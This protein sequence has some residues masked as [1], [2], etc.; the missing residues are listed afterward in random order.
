MTLARRHGRAVRILAR[1]K[2]VL[3]DG[4]ASSSS[5]TARPGSTPRARSGRSSPSRR[6]SCARTASSRTCAL[7][8]A[9]GQPIQILTVARQGRPGRALRAAPLERA[10]AR[11]GRAAALPG[12]EGRDRP[13]DRR[14]ASTTTSSSPSRSP[15]PTSSGSRTRSGASSPRAASGRREE[16]DRRRGARALRG[17]GRAV[18]GRARRHRRGRRSASTRSAR[19]PSEFT[20][21][22]R[23]PHLQ[24]SR[25]DQGVQAD[26]PRRRLLARRRAATSS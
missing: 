16:I 14:T 18:Q 17:R 23:G 26:G 4:R 7:P 8:L 9:D 3:P 25:A 24:D 20:D 15:R 10:P 2:V 5:P 12:R 21:L 22:C 13:A 1:M 11:R 6:C 19:R